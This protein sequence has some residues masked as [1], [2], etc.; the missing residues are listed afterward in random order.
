MLPLMVTWLLSSLS[1]ILTDRRS[2]NLGISQPE[3]V[4]LVSHD[5]DSDIKLV[6]FGLAK[7]LK[8]GEII[9]DMVGTP[10]FVGEWV[11]NLAI[12]SLL[13]FIAVACEIF[14]CYINEQLCC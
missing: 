5:K 13:C 7:M 9:R 11:E 1:L 2:T 12:I 6:D 14:Q 3:N 4:L 10:E 8:E